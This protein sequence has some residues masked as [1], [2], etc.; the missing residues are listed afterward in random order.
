VD[1]VVI[2][3]EEADRDSIEDDL[4]AAGVRLGRQINPVLVD[5][6][7]WDRAETGFLRTLQSRP[8][9]ELTTHEDEHVD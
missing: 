5:R 7:D 4:A 6:A 3:D 8:L 2:V 1:V 9:V